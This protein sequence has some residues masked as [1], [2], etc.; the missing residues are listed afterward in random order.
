MTVKLVKEK[1]VIPTYVPRKAMDLPMFFERKPYQGASGRLYPLPF[2]DSISDEKTDVTYDVYTLENEYIKTDLLPAL[3]G[4][5]LRGYDKCGDY[6]F[7]YYNEVV[8][9]ALVGLAGPWISGGIEFNYPQHHRPTTYHPAEAVMEESADGEKTVWMGEVE[10]FNR[11]KGMVGVS[12]EPGRSYIKAK[13]K[14]YNR[15]NQSQLFMWWANLAVPVNETYKTIFPPDVEWVNDHDR[16]CVMSWPIAKGVFHTARPFDYGE[17]TDISKYDSVKVPSSFLV[18]QGQ[19]D[20]DFVA[21]YDGGKQ[22][23]IATV[24]NH[25]I[26][27]GK[28]MWTWGKGDFGEMWCN[29][30]TDENGPYIELMTGVYTD[31]QPDFTWLNPGETRTFEQYWYPIRDIGDVKNAGIDAAVNVEQRG[32]R[33]FVG[34]NVTGVFKNTTIKVY[35]KNQTVFEE[36]A[37]MAPDSAWLKELPMGDWKLEDIAAALFAENGKELISHRHYVRGQKQPIEP[38]KPVARPQEIDTVDELYLNGLHLE[39]YK[40][41]NYDAKDYFWKA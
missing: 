22:L 16:R 14:V 32:D 34:F 3:G 10:P 24:A 2:S 38:R 12:V 6:D 37:D 25:H 27:P 1:R 36:T 26:A 19:S 23:G 31:N 30:L 29:N 35:H 39:Q 20:L 15:T 11:L 40:Q 17:G 9:P 8:K 41:H 33:L 7:I 13:I 21:G 18:S 5:I 4:K 28:K